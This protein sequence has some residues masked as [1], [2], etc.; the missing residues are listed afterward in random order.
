MVPEV[1]FLTT[2]CLVTYGM[3]TMAIV[4][5]FIYTSVQ[6]SADFGNT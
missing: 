6:S 3:V 2:V 5:F 1:P 4:L